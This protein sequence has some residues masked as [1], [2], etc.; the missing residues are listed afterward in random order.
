MGSPRVIKLRTLA[1]T[2]VMLALALLAA[3]LLETGII[4]ETILSKYVAYA[5]IIVLGV[6]SIALIFLSLR[7]YA[8]D[9]GCNYSK[10]KGF[11]L[12]M[13][14]VL[15][16]GSIFGAILIAIPTLIPVIHPV[17][18][19]MILIGSSTLFI[20]DVGFAMHAYAKSN[21]C[22]D[23]SVASKMR[24]SVKIGGKAVVAEAGSLQAEIDAEVK[25]LREAGRAK[26][27]RTRNFTSAEL[28]EL[29]RT[30]PPS[31]LDNRK[32]MERQRSS[33]SSTA[34]VPRSAPAYSSMPSSSRSTASEY[35]RFQSSGEYERPN[36][37][38][39]PY[40]S[41]PGYGPYYAPTASQ[42]IA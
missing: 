41:A 37:Y 24:R 6:A 19:W 17:F 25:R 33:S 14:L 13:L 26:Y 10:W 42:M 21:V 23:F 18:A 29:R 3:V 2:A 36:L 8:L 22:D 35:G 32:K 39:P 38:A 11:Q 34:A 1:F 40:T 15:A 30:T 27:G 31:R 9:D 7:K 16:L 4:P 20:V 12:W 28:T 5:I